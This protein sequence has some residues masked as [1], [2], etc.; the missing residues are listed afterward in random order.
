MIL[1]SNHPGELRVRVT[2]RS[3]IIG[4]MLTP[5]TCLFVVLTEV[6]WQSGYPT[7]L[8]LMYHVVFVIFWLTL[9]NLVVQRFKPDWA[10]SPA[11]LL[12]IFTMLSVSSALCG[13]DMLQV[14]VPTL[15]H[16][17]WTH[18]S[19]GRF[20]EIIPHVPEWLVVRGSGGVDERL[21]R[22][23]IGVRPGELRAVARAVGVVVLVCDGA[24]VR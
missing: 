13:H 23:G 6:M 5:A 10:L 20:G 7:I 8:S 16:L 19:E 11:E 22:P 21:R 3:I 12:V 4:L 15:S 24:C 2:F 17:H 1:P 9:G 18:L 14:L